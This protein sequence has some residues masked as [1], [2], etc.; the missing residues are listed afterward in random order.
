[1]ISRDPV[2]VAAARGRCHS[3]QSS[4][5]HGQTLQLV[6]NIQCLRIYFLCLL[7]KP[8]SYKRRT[9]SAQNL[10]ALHSTLGFSDPARS[11]LVVVAQFY[12]HFSY[13]SSPPTCQ[14]RH[15]RPLTSRPICLLAARAPTI[16]E[17][18]QVRSGALFRLFSQTLSHSSGFSFGAL[19]SGLGSTSVKNLSTVSSSSGVAECPR[20][21]YDSNRTW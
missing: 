12:D 1:M 13:L 10:A 14:P 21:G 19:A 20:S 6:H 17:S 11:R 8:E 4:I 15:L 16:G 3:C 5:L 7:Q 2:L 9:A 18:G